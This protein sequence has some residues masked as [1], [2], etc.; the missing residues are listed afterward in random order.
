MTVN[1]HKPLLGK[2]VGY[3][4]ELLIDWYMGKRKEKSNRLQFQQQHLF[5]LHLPESRSL[6]DKAREFSTIDKV[7][8]QV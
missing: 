8:L 1:I 2:N 6:F 7:P 5:Q 4:N 3:K